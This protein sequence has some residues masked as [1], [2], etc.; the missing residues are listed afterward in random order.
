[1]NQTMQAARYS[2]FGGPEVIVF[3]TCPIPVPRAGEVLVRVVAAPVTAGDVRIRSGRVPRGMGLLLRL[4]M[5]LRRPRVGAGWGFSGEV[6]ALGAGVAGLT[7]GQPVFGVKGFAGGAHAQYLTLRADGALLPLPDSLT[8]VEGAAFF[9]GG[10]TAAVFLIDK[11]KVQRG[12][13]VLVSGATGAVGSAAVQIAAHLGA[14]VTASASL[15]NLEL[16]RKLGAAHLHDYRSGPVQGEFDVILDVMGTLGWA[17][18][19]LAKA[20]RLCLITADLA[21]NLAA[22]MRQNRGG[23]RAFAGTSG[24]TRAQM[25]RL[26]DLHLAGAYRPHIGQ[27]LPFEQLPAAHAMADGFHKPGNLVVLMPTSQVSNV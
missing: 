17:K 6:V 18:P 15:Q 1:M 27:T 8:H 19:L 3:D 11:A 13:R 7:V 16:A 9:F 12:D 25:Q 22:P 21:T 10:L 26:V 4:V 24:E 14:E 2:A 5:G 23:Q 20:G